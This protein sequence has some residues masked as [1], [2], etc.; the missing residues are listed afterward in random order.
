MHGNVPSAEKVPVGHATLWICA[1]NET[2]L[3]WKPSVADTVR[4]KRPWI[5]ASNT[6]FVVMIPV[7]AST[8]NGEVCRRRPL[9][10]SSENVMGE[11]SASVAVSW[12]STVPTVALSSRATADGIGP[13]C[14]LLSSTLVTATVRSRKPE[15][16]DCCALLPEIRRVYAWVVSKSSPPAETDTSPLAG[17]ITKALFTLPETIEYKN[18]VGRA[19]T[20]VEVDGTDPVQTTPA[21]SECAQLWTAA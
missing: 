11:L 20:D 1:R 15:M 2:V 17:L 3:V 21:S 6:W 13:N 4:L 10:E 8:T 19:T 7:V 18:A 14:G 12:I 9:T 16:H 5:E